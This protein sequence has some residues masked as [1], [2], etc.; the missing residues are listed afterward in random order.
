MTIQSSPLMGASLV[1]YVLASAF[2]QAPLF[3]RSA[4]L[5]A[6][7]LRLAVVAFA[8]HSAVLAQHVLA[9]HVELADMREVL[10]VFAWALLLVYLVG[11]LR[12]G[13]EPLGALVLPLGMVAVLAVALA[14]RTQL[15]SVALAQGTA[16][17]P[18]HIILGVAAYGAFFVAFA[19]AL[20][21]LLKERLLKAKRLTG[22]ARRLPSLDQAESVGYRF[23]ALGFLLWTIM[24]GTGMALNYIAQ[25]RLWLWNPKQTLALVTWVIYAAYLHARLISDYRGRTSVLLLVFSFICAALTWGGVYVVGDPLHASMH[26]LLH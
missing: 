23:A 4:R 5:N 16:L 2:Y 20:A 12:Y 7:A 24:M 6:W 17:M 15:E 26:R 22:L 1:V 25:A 9:G 10:L 11:R 3:L 8:L 21:Y 19:S 18:I 14:P 13:I